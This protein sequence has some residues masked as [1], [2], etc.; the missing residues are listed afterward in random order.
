MININELINH[1]Q[2]QLPQSFLSDFGIAMFVMFEPSGDLRTAKQF[3][4][5][6]QLLFCGTCS[7]WLR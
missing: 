1:Y 3:P 6:I 7:A 2:F 5:F 4:R